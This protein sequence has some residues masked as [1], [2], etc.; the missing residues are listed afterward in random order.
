MPTYMPLTSQS[1]AR[2]FNG[3]VKGE[4]DCYLNGEYRYTNTNYYEDTKHL[5]TVLNHWNNIADRMKTPRFDGA[6]F[7][8]E[9]KVKSVT[10][11]KGT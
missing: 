4:V 2:S 11:L 9:Y 6:I 1:E 5:Q 8:Y 3:A 7:I 10:L